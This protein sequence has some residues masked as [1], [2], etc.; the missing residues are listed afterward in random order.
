MSEFKANAALH[1]SKLKKRNLAVS[2]SG[3]EPN[4]KQLLAGGP[5]GASTQV[6]N[7]NSIIT[8]IEAHQQLRCKERAS[9]TQ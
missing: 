4:L 8:R 5:A 3:H 1:R 6:L 9:L 2:Q 7:N